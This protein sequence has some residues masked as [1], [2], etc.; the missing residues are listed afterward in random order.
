M[1]AALRTRTPSTPSRGRKSR[2]P[3]KS[4]LFAMSRPLPRIH[5]L[6]DRSGFPILYHHG[7]PTSGRLYERWQTE[8][9]RLIGFDR[10]RYAGSARRPGRDVAS[11]AADVEAIAD[12]LALERFATWG[13]S[14]GRPH[15]LA[16]AAL[17]GDRL[18]AAASLAGVAPWGAEGLDWLGGMG[19][20]N[21]REFGLALAGEEALGPALEDG[22][23]ELLQKTPESLTEAWTSLLGETDRAA[24]TGGLASFLHRGTGDAVKD[25]VDGWLDDDLAFASAWG[26][27]PAEIARPVLIVQGGDDRFVPRSHGE[28]LGE[29]TPGC[30]TWFDERHGHLTLYEHAVPDVHAWLLEHS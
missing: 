27:D 24:L 9:V 26:F 11:V 29:A 4:K 21:V 5:E 19:E 23:A 15:A 2:T 28:W 25:G 18:T 3:E 14:G 20:E 22:R 16:C 7:T 10:S 6:G 13:I 30:E 12:A 8:G 1:V 17:C